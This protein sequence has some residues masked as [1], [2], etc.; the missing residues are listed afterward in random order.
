MELLISD[1]KL[2]EYAISYRK[3]KGYNMNLLLKINR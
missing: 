2:R 1:I 3:Y